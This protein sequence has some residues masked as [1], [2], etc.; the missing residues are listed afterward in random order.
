[1]THLRPATGSDIEL[2]KR[3]LYT[4]LAWDPQDPIPPLETVVT[5]PVIEIYWKGWMRPGDAGV[6]A[7][8]EG[9][10]VGMAYCR[11]FAADAGSQGFV[12]A[13][14]PEL[15]IGVDSA[16]RGEGIGGQLIRSLAASLESLAVARMSLSVNAPNPAMR[17]YERLGF[18]VVRHHDAD[19]VM[20]A[21]VAAIANR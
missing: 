2:V 6:V 13:A 7:E 8:I 21:A 3:T 16:H 14:T 15:A 19:V 5:H 17:L 11:L 20:D 10:A 18:E 1:M 12:D 9:K 4:A